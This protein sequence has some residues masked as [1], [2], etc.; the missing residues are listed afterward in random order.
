MKTSAF[1]SVIRKRYLA[2]KEIPSK[3][4]GDTRKS[5][6]LGKVIWDSDEFHNL[7]MHPHVI[8]NND[9][10]IIHIS[11]HLFRRLEKSEEY[12]SLVHNIFDLAK[13]MYTNANL[14]SVYVY[15]RSSLS[16][17]VIAKL[18]SVESIVTYHDERQREFK[19]LKNLMWKYHNWKQKKIKDK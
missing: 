11:L 4:F 2:K 12:S 6:E 1:Q 7:I 8:D 18:D 5:A 10:K 9:G 14:Y 3:W 19:F 16:S 15:H 13:D 17:K